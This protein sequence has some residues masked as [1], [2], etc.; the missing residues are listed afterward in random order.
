MNLYKFES[1]KVNTF[2]MVENYH[3]IVVNTNNFSK[4]AKISNNI[5]ML[6]YMDG[7][8]LFDRL[9]YKDK[10]YANLLLIPNQIISSV[11]SLNNIVLNGIKINISP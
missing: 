5:T 7:L 6:R 8:T 11:L 3:Q 2:K 9:N 1:K 10:I 4:T